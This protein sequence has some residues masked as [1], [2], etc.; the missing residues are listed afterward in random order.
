MLGP[1]MKDRRECPLGSD[2]QKRV[3]GPCVLQETPGQSSSSTHSFQEKP[4]SQLQAGLFSFNHFYWTILSVTL[5][6]S[7][8][9]KEKNERM[10]NSTQYPSNPAYQLKLFSSPIHRPPTL[11]PQKNHPKNQTKPTNQPKTP[12]TKWNK[13]T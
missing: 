10:E 2:L 1:Q 4:T 6:I 12:K 13:N 3:P 7:I 5:Y 8:L 9:G 11:P